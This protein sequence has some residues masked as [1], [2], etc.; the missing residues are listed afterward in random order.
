MK[1]H[2]PVTLQFLQKSV[3]KS[4][5]RQGERLMRSTARKVP[6]QIERN[7]GR[8]GISFLADR[9]VEVGVETERYNFWRTASD[10]TSRCD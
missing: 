7:Q 6:P 10:R 5:E 3:P 1:F 2:G 4:N 9:P 8:N